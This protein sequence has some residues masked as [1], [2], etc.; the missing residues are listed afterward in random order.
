MRDAC[1]VPRRPKAT[2]S[3]FARAPLFEVRR[4]RFTHSPYWH[5]HLLHKVSQNKTE[6][7]KCNYININSILPANNVVLRNSCGS[8]KVV[9]KQHTD[10]NKGMCYFVMYKSFER[11]S[12]NQN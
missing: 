7:I 5:T 11:G 1:A 6:Q 3:Q 2:V 4:V 12:T 9:A 8:N 10:V